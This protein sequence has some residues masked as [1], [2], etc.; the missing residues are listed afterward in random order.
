[1]RLPAPYG[2]IDALDE[3]GK[4]HP[5]WL[6]WLQHVYDSM[7]WSTNSPM[8]DDMH[9]VVHGVGAEAVHDGIVQLPEH[10]AGS[11][12]VA[13]LSGKLPNTY[14]EGSSLEPYIEW[15]PVDGNAGNVVLK[16]AYAIS[17][18]GSALGSAVVESTTVAVPVVS[19]QITRTAFT[20]ISGS[21][22]QKGDNIAV[23]FSRDGADAADTYASSILAARYG[24]KIH[25]EG[26]GHERAHP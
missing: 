23:A 1:M 15:L 11:E 22:L 5:D 17:R 4:L 10:S 8:Y 12:D 3:G 7:G 20:A 2:A 16:V 13:R 24:V 9:L 14:R 18:N 26:V 25:V 21:S 6:R 19:D